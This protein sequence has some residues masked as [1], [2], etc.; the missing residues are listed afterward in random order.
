[1]GFLTRHLSSPSF[2]IIL[3]R[4]RPTIIPWDYL[5]KRS[6]TQKKPLTLYGDLPFRLTIRNTNPMLC[7]A[8]LPQRIE[9]PHRLTSTRTPL[10]ALSMHLSKVMIICDKGAQK[11]LTWWPLLRST[12][13]GEGDEILIY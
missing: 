9:Q 1:M 8:T 13:I 4:C 7:G 5:W 10:R 12:S 6:T 2:P 3:S 11:P